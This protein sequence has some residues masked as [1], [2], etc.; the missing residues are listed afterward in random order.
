M[1]RCCV[2]VAVGLFC[3]LDVTALSCF[4]VGMRG[5][6]ASQDGQTGDKIRACVSS[7]LRLRCGV[8]VCRFDYA[9]VDSPLFGVSERV[10]NC[11]VSESVTKQRSI[12]ASIRCRHVREVNR[13][14][15]RKTR[16]QSEPAAARNL[17]FCVSRRIHAEPEHFS[18]TLCVSCTALFCGVGLQTFSPPP[19]SQVRRSYRSTRRTGHEV[20]LFRPAGGAGAV[21]LCSW[22]HDV[23]LFS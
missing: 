23:S 19:L 14:N 11:Q 10:I 21:S 15:I 9:A 3:I 13:T 8:A 17:N 22:P 4:F 5:V 16:T 18:R 1:S 6:V 2:G 7:R 12:S 20:R